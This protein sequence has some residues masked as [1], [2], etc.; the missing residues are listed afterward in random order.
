LNSILDLMGSQ[1]RSLRIGVIWLDFFA[2]LINRAAACWTRRSFAS[3]ASDRPHN[4]VLKW[5]SR[6][7]TYACT[8]V[9]VC[10]VVIY[11]LILLIFDI[12]IHADLQTLSIWTSIDICSS[13]WAPIFLTTFLQGMDCPPTLIHVV[14]TFLSVDGEPRMMN[15][16]L[17]SFILSLLALIHV[18]SSSMQFSRF[19]KTSASSTPGWKDG[20]NWVSSA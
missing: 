8:K 15:S 20:Y 3:F 6:E 9:L 1:C 7:V 18:L 13:K 19:D 10:S 4:R 11:C 16:V 14:L 17:E 2:L 12:L 5:S